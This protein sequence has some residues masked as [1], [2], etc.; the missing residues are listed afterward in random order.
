MI[1]T[2]KKQLEFQKNGYLIFK[3]TYNSKELIN[4]KSKVNKIIK[5]AQIKKIPLTNKLGKNLRINLFNKKF[6]ENIISDFLN[7]AIKK[8]IFT[9][10]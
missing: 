4:L 1:F 9:I 3:N 5:L 10:W 6:T 8:K 7:I 2:K